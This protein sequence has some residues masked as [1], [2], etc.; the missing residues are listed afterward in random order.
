[1]NKMAGA[2]MGKSQGYGK[3]LLPT[4]LW[5][6][7][8]E[9]HFPTFS[10][11]FKDYLKLKVQKILDTTRL[12]RMAENKIILLLGI[13]NLVKTENTQFKRRRAILSSGK[14]VF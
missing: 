11:W 14:R 9:I 3:L 4:A 6:S 10:S 7:L 1:M 5:I 12:Q 2:G 13:M 8:R